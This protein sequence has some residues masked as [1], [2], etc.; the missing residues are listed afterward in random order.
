M[1]QAAYKHD[2]ADDDRPGVTDEHFA[3]Y[4]TKYH[5][6]T[7]T[8]KAWGVETLQDVFKLV[9]DTVLMENDVLAAA[10]TLK[11]TAEDDIAHF[12]K[13]AEENRRERQRR[14]DAGDETA[15]LKI[16]QSVMHQSAQEN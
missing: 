2:V 10:S 1:L 5:R 9:K 14:I 13:L 12:L 8:P 4:L 6:K 7:I 3:F 11:I 15:R 16:Q